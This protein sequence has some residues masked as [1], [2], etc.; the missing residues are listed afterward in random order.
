MP[1][2]GLLSKKY[3]AW[4]LGWSVEIPLTLDTY[5]SSNVE[6]GMFNFPSFSNQELEEIFNQIKPADSEDKKKLLYKRA[7]EIFE[8]K[9]PVTILFWSDNII[10]YNKRIKNINFSP[11]GLFSSAWKWE[12]EN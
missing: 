9:E 10:G 5:W 8:E 3:D 12:I 6:K 11:L 2:P 4:I 1:S 7:S